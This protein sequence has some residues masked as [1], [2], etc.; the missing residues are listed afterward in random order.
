MPGDRHSVNVSRG[1]WKDQ[2]Y[3]LFLGASQ[4]FLVRLGKKKTEI[5]LALAGLNRDFD[6][7]RIEHKDPTP[8]GHTISLPAV[9][10]PMQAYQEAIDEWTGC[11]FHNVDFDLDWESVQYKEWRFQ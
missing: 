7:T 11:G 5:R 9:K 2:K 3:E 6:R 4:R 10:S 1:R 8:L